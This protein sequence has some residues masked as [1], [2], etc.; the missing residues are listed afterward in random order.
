MSWDA[1]RLYLKNHH[2][3]RGA[4]GMLLTGVGTT[5]LAGAVVGLPSLV[6]ADQRLVPVL[7]VA[8]LLGAVLGGSTLHSAM[9]EFDQLAAIDLRVVRLLHCLVLV[10]VA[11]GVYLPGLWFG[12]LQ[13]HEIALA[14]RN[15][16]GYLALYLLAAAALGVRA[17]WSLPLLYCAGVAVYAS[18][19]SSDLPWW[20]W[21]V[22][23]QSRPDEWLWVVLSGLLGVALVT[24][25]GARDG[26]S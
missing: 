11:T 23:P 9:T 20:A 1:L 26:A 4:I 17:A 21:P 13:P 15:S 3:G 25:A 16:M 12:S 6:G 8:P 2:A 10:V 19:S 24:R 5:A 14:V 7:L 22:D 18:T